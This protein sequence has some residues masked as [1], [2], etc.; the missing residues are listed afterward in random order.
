MEYAEL[1]VT[2]VGILKQRVMGRGWSKGM[3]VVGLIQRSD[4]GKGP[5]SWN[6]GSRGVGGNTHTQDE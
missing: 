3:K 2:R 5:H 4:Y 6:W 1:D